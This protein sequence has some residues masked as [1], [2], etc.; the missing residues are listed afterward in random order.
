MSVEPN[1]AEFELPLTRK[2]AASILGITEQTLD[3]IKAK[4]EIGYMIFGGS[5]RFSAA[6]I[7]DYIEKHTFQPEN[8]QTAANR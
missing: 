1:T 6:Q 7:N 8:D 4:R 5:I 3:K 2:S